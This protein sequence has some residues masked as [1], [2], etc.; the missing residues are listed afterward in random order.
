MLISSLIV[1]LGLGL[2]WYFYGRKPIVSA[3]APDPVS[4]LSPAV[5]TVLG[6]AFYF[7][8]FYGATFIRLNTFLQDLRLARPLGLE[9]R[10]QDDH[11]PHIWICSFG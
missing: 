7:D 10:G 8:A 11:C 2:G 6:H 1:F 3:Q 4:R 9:R 5:F